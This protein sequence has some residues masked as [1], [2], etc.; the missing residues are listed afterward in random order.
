MGA[1]LPPPHM[2]VAPAGTVKKK[3][4]MWSLAY[5]SGEARIFNGGGGGG[6]GVR[7]WEGKVWGFPLPR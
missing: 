4:L 1:E 7:R 5:T 6:R 2:Y 3:T